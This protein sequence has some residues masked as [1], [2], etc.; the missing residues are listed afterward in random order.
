MRRKR[1]IN[2]PDTFI[3]SE[4][5][6][7]IRKSFKFELIT[8]MFGGDAK[9]W[10]LDLEKPVRGQAVKGQLRFWW[11]TMQNKTDP[12]QLLHNEN[13]LWGGKVADNKRLKSN[14]S[15]SISDYIINRNKDIILAT[16]A[17]EYAVDDS[18]MPT[19]VLFPITKKV[20]DGEQIYLIKKFYF[21]LNISYPQE[22]EL[23]ILNTLKLW[24]LFGGIGARTRR[25][26]GSIF[27]EELLEGLNNEDDIYKFLNLISNKANGGENKEKKQLDYPRISNMK[28]YAAN[29]PP[30]SK[31][32]LASIWKNLLESY[33][34][35]RQDR[36]PGKVPGRSYW[37]EPDAIRSMTDIYKKHIPSHPDGKWF[38]R[39]AFG[40]PMQIKYKDNCDPGNKKEINI[41][42]DINSGE[43]YPS[44]VIIKVIK[45]N[46]DS[47]LKCVL[48]LNQIFPDK[49][50]FEVSKKGYTIDKSMLPFHSGYKTTKIM[51]I[52]HELKGKSI[53]DNLAEH[54][55]L[56][57]LK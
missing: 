54:L 53:Y 19:Y 43:R 48:I 26:T 37:P 1:I 11:R 7:I 22:N 20:K 13:K 8:P 16:M 4:N 38:P 2:I 25:G 5:N 36:V 40:L 14:V 27:C 56:K 42:P 34:K 23:E 9:S 50:K 33:G 10:Q 52:G 31:K 47:I 32:G 30:N 29:E 6:N 44:P 17:N 15:L 45:L 49:L 3:Q 46:N 39:T 12:K 28:F 21:T 24:T 55:K 18:V 51:R 35:Y 57:E 41:V